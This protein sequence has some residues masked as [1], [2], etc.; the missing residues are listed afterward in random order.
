[1]STEA[2]V[3]FDQAGRRLPGRLA[4]R[5][6]P[7]GLGRLDRF[8]HAIRNFGHIHVRPVRGGVMVEFTPRV[9]SRLAAIAAFY[10]IGDRAP[11]KIVL[12]C[13]GAVHRFEIFYRRG[14]ACRRIEELIRQ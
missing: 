6:P 5:V 8:D 2:A 3:I 13:P 12:A 7:E 10:E 1:M 9:A 4:L 11:E 14:Q